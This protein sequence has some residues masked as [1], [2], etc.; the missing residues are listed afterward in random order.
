MQRHRGSI[1]LNVMFFLIIISLI[2]AGMGLLMVSDYSLGGVESDY[3][4]AMPVAEAGINYELHKITG[5]GLL[6][7][8]KQFIGA[9]GIP[10]TTTAGT[11]SVYVTQRNDDGTE[12]TPWIPGNNLWIYST[13]T[14]HKVTR[15]LK[16]A[17]V[18]YGRSSVL[19]Y[20]VF[21]VSQGLM[22][23]S[24]TTV[25]G[26]VGTD[27]FLNFTGHPTI[28]GSPIFNGPASNWQSPPSGTYATLFNLNPIIWPT[29]ESI[30]IKTFGPL[31]LT[32]VALHNDNALASPAIFLNMVLTNGSTDQTFV[33]K[34][35]GANYYLTS[36]TCSGNSQIIFDNTN[37]PIT[38]W[39]GPS[40]VPG[41]FNLQG[42]TAAIKMSQDPTKL[43]R[44][45]IATTNDVILGGNSELDA[46]I[47]NVNNSG[48]GRMIFNGTPSI[49]GMMIGNMFTFNG[50][51]TVTSVQGYFMPQLSVSYYGCTQPWQEMG[52]V[53]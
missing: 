28:T 14:V 19:N 36:L 42:G 21:G 24:A 9:P 41:T 26:D 7:D 8:Q 43:V 30:A 13:G 2:L 16:V 38:L 17:A 35:G 31:G 6:A 33:G 22:N 25:N 46:G 3:A 50:N 1:L 4:N 47:Y 34:P 10:Y 39:F 45:Y 23:G 51:P 20:T 49:Y 40:G 11:F 53:N 27:G 52:G 37:G 15:T 48:A 12:T 44:V 18:P 32:Y 5:D 29:V